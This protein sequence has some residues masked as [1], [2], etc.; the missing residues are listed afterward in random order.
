M[1]VS[2]G[3]NRKGL[4]HLV[5]EFRLRTAEME[6]VRNHLGGDFG[7]F[8]VVFRKII[9]VGNREI[10]MYVVVNEDRESGSVNGHINFLLKYDREVY[11]SENIDMIRFGDVITL[12][13]GDRIH[14]IH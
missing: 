5:Y 12:G 11:S 6:K 2:F 8:G 1:I 7:R 4:S 3:N 13:N 9:W 14:I 10:T